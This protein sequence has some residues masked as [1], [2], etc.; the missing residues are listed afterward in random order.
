MT[1]SRLAS[2]RPARILLAA[3]VLTAAWQGWLACQAGPKIPADLDRYVSE[4]GAVD[5]LVVLRFPPE[6]FHILTFQKFGRVSGTRD[7][8]VEVRA[9]PRRRVREIARLYWVREIRPLTD[10]A[11]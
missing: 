8:A 3:A 1:P 6:R 2:S 5:L 11:P 10:E 9:V 4:R 7:H